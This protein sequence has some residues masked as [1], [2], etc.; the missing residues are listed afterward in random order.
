MKKYETTLVVVPLYFAERDIT[1]GTLSCRLPS[2]SAVLLFAGG[3][4]HSTAPNT[5]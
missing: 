5:T 4:I 3:V 1:N 2:M